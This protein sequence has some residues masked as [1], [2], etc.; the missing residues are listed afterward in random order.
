MKVKPID[1]DEDDDEDPGQSNEGDKLDEEA[2]IG[3]DFKALDK[4]QSWWKWQQNGNIPFFP[5]WWKKCT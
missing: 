2:D 3:D 5:Y 1:V 4:G